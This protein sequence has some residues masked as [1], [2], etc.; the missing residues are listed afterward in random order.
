MPVRARADPG[1]S[2]RDVRTC[3]ADDATTRGDNGDDDVTSRGRDEAGDPY[4]DQNG[5]PAGDQSGESHAHRD[6]LSRVAG[7]CPSRVVACAGRGAL[8]TF[9]FYHRGP[10]RRC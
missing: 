2:A 8:R 10:G 9:G 1:S 7:S 5:G 3:R 4:D 6:D